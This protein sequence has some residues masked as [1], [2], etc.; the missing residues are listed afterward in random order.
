MRALAAD[1]PFVLAGTRLGRYT[2]DVKGTSL[3]YNR[4]ACALTIKKVRS[5]PT[6][7]AG[8]AV[9]PPRRRRP[10]RFT[11]GVRG[12]ARVSHPCCGA[13]QHGVPTITKQR[14]ACR[15]AARGACSRS[16]RPLPATT[17]TLTPVDPSAHPPAW[18]YCSR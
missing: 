17:R 12:A 1:P 13:L 8:L 16:V 14:L 3:P 18:F 4:L 2:V 10:P 11:C 7:A 6:R 5:P 15:Q 9:R